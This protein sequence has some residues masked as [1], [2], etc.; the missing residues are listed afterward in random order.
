MRPCARRRCSVASARPGSRRR[1][2]GSRPGAAGHPA[3][4]RSSL[5]RRTTGCAAGVRWTGASAPDAEPRRVVPHALRLARDAGPW[6][7][8]HNARKTSP[9]AAPARHSPAAFRPRAVLRGMADGK[10]PLPSDA[11]PSTDESHRRPPACRPARPRPSCQNRRRACRRVC[12]TVC[13]KASRR[14]CGTASET[15]GLHV[16]LKFLLVLLA[17]RRNNG[18]HFA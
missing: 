5:A 3:G 10:H 12:Q 16:R 13:R 1:G 9:S 17:A 14:A 15:P 18:G 6:D 11:A 4:R 2:G 7:A 8:W